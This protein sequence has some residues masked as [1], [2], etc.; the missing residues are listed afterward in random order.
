MPLR[1][2]STCSSINSCKSVSFDEMEHTVYYTHS[3]NEYDR[4]IEP[5]CELLVGAVED[6]QDPLVERNTFANG[7][8]STSGYAVILTLR[9]KHV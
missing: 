4:T 6:E 5:R 2:S 8:R 1:R 3:A 7:R 9:N